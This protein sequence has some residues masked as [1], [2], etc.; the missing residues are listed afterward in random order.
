MHRL[1]DQQRRRRAADADL[2]LVEDRDD[3]RQREQIRQRHGQ[4][5]VEVVEGQAHHG[6]SGGLAFGGLEQ[7]AAVPVDVL[8]DDP[9]QRRVRAPQTRHHQRGQ[10][11]VDG[12][13]QAQERRGQVAH[14]R[15]QHRTG[16][17]ELRGVAGRGLDRPRCGEASARI[18]PQPDPRRRVQPQFGKADR[19]TE[20]VQ[21][22]VSGLTGD[23]PPARGPL[24]IR[25]RHRPPARQ[26]RRDEQELA[27]GDRPRGPRAPAQRIRRETGGRD[28]IDGALE[29]QQ[30]PRDRPPVARRTGGKQHRRHRSSGFSVHV[31]AP[32]EQLPRREPL[33]DEA[34]Q[35]RGHRPD[36]QHR[37]RLG[38]L[39]PLGRGVE[40]VG[41]RVER[42][43]HVGGV[44]VCRADG[45]AGDGLGYAHACPALSGDSSL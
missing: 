10:P 44:L 38:V 16:D 45:T 28:R 37:P 43:P 20:T 35:R 11:G 24:V 26:R 40:R 12:A 42:P 14:R 21:R 29:R 27:L 15:A 17:G 7:P 19:R 6:R 31:G 22:Q 33:R 13:V 39:E 4:V 8:R 1:Q 36:P 30:R 3:V 25:H 34:E 23:P 18:A 41:I 2:E 5:V 9:A 32:V